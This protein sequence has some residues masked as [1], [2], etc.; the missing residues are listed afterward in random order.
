MYKRLS[1]LFA[2]AIA[3]ACLQ[4][5]AFADEIRDSRFLKINYK[6]PPP[7]TDIASLQLW[8]TSDGGESWMAVKTRKLTPPYY[9]D[10]EVPADGKYG[11]RIVSYD[12]AG[13]VQNK[14]SN[15][16]PPDK[17]VI[18]DTTNPQISFMHLQ[19]V[20]KIRVDEKYTIKWEA[21]D[22][23]FGDYPIKIEYKIVGAGSGEGAYLDLVKQNDGWVKNT[24]K[25][26]VVFDL[27]ISQ[28]KDIKIR[29]TA[30][31][32][33]GH[34]RTALKDG[35]LLPPQSASDSTSK[36]AGLTAPKAIKAGADGFDISWRVT[37]YNTD[38]VL[39]T[40]WYRHP[41]TG[42][43]WRRYKETQENPINFK[44]QEGD[45]DG[46]YYFYLGARTLT[47][48]DIYSPFQPDRRTEP[49]TEVLV[50]RSRPKVV[51]NPVELVSDSGEVITPTTPGV[52]NGGDKLGITWKVHEAIELQLD[53][54]AIEVSFDG[55]ETYERIVGISQVEM[56][57]NEDV[58]A[59]RQWEGE[60]I[61]T[62]P[63]LAGES[64]VRV[65]VV[66][67][68]SVGNVGFARTGKFIV[69]SFADDREND[70]IAEKWF[71][72]GMS[73]YRRM[74]ER[75]K[76]LRAARD[77]F[78]ESLLYGPGDPRT[79]L[80]LAQ[81]LHKLG[82]LDDAIRYAE[83]ARHHTDSY[84]CHMT[85]TVLYL[86]RGRLDSAG[87]SIEKIINIDEK[88][89]LT[90]KQTHEVCRN[91]IRLVEKF[92][93]RKEYDAGIQYVKKISKLRLSKV[94]EEYKRRAE[95]L[96]DELKRLAGKKYEEGGDERFTD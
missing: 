87:R 42:K 45:P 49:I 37:N 72:R 12:S 68:D 16:D 91:I 40:L 10:V 78:L 9:F 51:M 28:P 38:Q 39:A 89:P 18:V 31:D 80:M 5:A 26:E 43:E 17:S 25:A 4:R 92:K 74:D 50:D 59:K 81:T 58:E 21:E 88:E 75:Q 54:T 27:P 14:P 65:K 94:T 35:Q 3:L 30:M 67:Y 86:E 90:D 53:K 23:N 62:V 79:L 85:L 34:A 70:K 11:F 84:E 44:L 13:N 73:L 36:M 20:L 52:Y 6:A 29:L 41:G 66:V 82:M 32:R 93:T 69:R 95:E 57:E 63:R 22:E 56:R 7:G 2:L 76:N 33:A 48:E 96:E 60:F 47:R 46:Y 8:M 64:H 83:Q 61:W 55:G 19:P 77:A 1:V 71:K 15:G 24:G